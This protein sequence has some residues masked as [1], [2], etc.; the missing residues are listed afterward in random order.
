VNAKPLILVDAQ[1]P[2]ALKNKSRPSFADWRLL[3]GRKRY[4]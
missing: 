2:P 4:Q 3:S 1:H